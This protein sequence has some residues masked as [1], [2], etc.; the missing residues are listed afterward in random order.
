MKRSENGLLRL[1][2][3]VYEKQRSWFCLYSNVSHSK[4]PKKSLQSE[5]EGG[6]DKEQNLEPSVMTEK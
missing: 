1:Y 6:E 3:W 5:K 2:V 4:R